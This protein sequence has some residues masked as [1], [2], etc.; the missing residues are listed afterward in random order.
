[1]PIPVRHNRGEVSILIRGPLGV[2]GGGQMMGRNLGLA[3]DEIG[4]LLLQPCRDAGVHLLALCAQ[5][6]AVGGV[7]D[8]RVL[9]EIRRL[10]RDA[11]AEQDPCRG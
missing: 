7:L 8:Q 2:A 10:R 4:E 9:E 3:L 6:G 1:M 5:Q 11:A